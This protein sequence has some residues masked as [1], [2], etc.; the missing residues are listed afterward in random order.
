[1]TREIT[2]SDWRPHASWTVLRKRAQML[3]M[4]RE[5][6]FTQEVLEV[7]TPMLSA[8]A[9]TDPHI[10]SFAT[11]YEGPGVV[12]KHSMYLHSSPEFPMKR[13]LAAGSGAI[14]QICKVFRNGECGQKH[15]PEFTMIEWYRP[16]FNLQGMM[17]DVERL[18]RYLLCIEGIACERVSYEELFSR[19][20]GFDPHTASFKVL[21]AAVNQAGLNVAGLHD[22]DRDACLNLLLTHIIEPQLGQDGMCFVYD[23]PASQAALAQ[24][25]HDETAVAERFELYMNG[26][27]LANGYLELRD[28]NELSQRMQQDL[29]FRQKESTGAVSADAHLLAAMAHGFPACSGVALGFDRLVMLAVGAKVLDEVLAFPFARA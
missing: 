8:A 19:Y 10:E 20:L 27:E 29:V 26:C 2:Q 4:A 5:Y 18:V 3:R 11:Y 22:D 13:L 16:G 1:M 12:N 6:F 28:S 9:V 24:L 25:R 23:Y 14:Y 17:D 15:N 21:Y 7:E